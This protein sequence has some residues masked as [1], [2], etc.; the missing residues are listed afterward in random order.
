M[1]L[2]S[3]D[4]GAE[5]LCDVRGLEFPAVATGR[6]ADGWLPVDPTVPNVSYRRVRAH[7]VKEVLARPKS[8]GQLSL[9]GRCDD[10]SDPFRTRATASEGH[11]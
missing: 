9:G 1:N 8:S 10:G 4:A 11:K 3:V 7:Q 5:V 6:S 2:R